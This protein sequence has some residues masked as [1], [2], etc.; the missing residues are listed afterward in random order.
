[1]NVPTVNRFKQD[2]KEMEDGEIIDDSDDESRLVDNVD[3]LF[4][5]YF[6]Y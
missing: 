2:L 3:K 5:L 1:M 4:L 6:L